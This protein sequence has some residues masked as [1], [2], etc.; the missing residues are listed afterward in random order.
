MVPPFVAVQGKCYIY[1]DNLVQRRLNALDE[2]FCRYDYPFHAA[3][4]EIL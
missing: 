1:T 2:E 3:I 4:R